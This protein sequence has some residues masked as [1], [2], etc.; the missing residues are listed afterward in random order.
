VLRLSLG[1]PFETST[2]IIRLILAG[3]LDRYP[4]LQLV[5]MHGGGT[6][7][8][9]AGRLDAYSREANLPRA[10]SA[11]LRN[12]YV[13]GLVYHAAALRCAIEVIG[14]DRV[15]FGTDHPFGIDSMR[16][17]SEALKRTLRHDEERALGQVNAARLFGVAVPA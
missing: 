6:V 3:T 13:D 1:F 12:V 10:P 8:F 16:A 4:D 11:Y 5:L 2:A 14:I 17:Q 7:P 9:L 15:L